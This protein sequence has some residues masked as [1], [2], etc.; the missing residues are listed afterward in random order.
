M[1]MLGYKKPAC[2]RGHISP[3]RTSHGA[4]IPCAKVYRR[5]TYERDKARRIRISMERA[6]E[7][8]EARRDQQRAHRLGVP[9]GEVRAAIARAGGRCEACSRPIT[10]AEMCIDHCH[11][12]GRIRGVLCRFCNALE[13][14]LNKQAGRVE[15]VL[16]YLKRAE[17][18]YIAREIERQKRAGV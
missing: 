3:E 6:K 12:S 2:K 9:V 18:R 8:P 10:H 14:M 7:N 17:D 4:C 13:G 5:E 15:Q 16:D 1:G 11:E